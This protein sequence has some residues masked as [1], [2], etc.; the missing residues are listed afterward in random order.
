MKSMIA[1][2]AAEIAERELIARLA[3]LPSWPPSMAVLWV[4]GIGYLIAFFDITNV[5]F[6]LPVFSKVLH[7][8]TSQ[9]ALPITA[10]LLGYVVGSWLNSNFADAMGRKTGIATATL[11]FT[12][13]CIATTFSQSITSMVVGRFVT[14]MGIG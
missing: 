7:L 8:S 11:L 3:R 14:G 1:A 13:G 5:A 9:Q 6:G 10:S 2:Q 12:V 4:V